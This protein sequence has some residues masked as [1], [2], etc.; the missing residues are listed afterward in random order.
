MD[1]AKSHKSYRPLTV[2][3]FRLNHVFH[4]MD[5]VAFHATN[6]GIHALVCALF[7]AACRTLFGQQSRSAL[8]AA[9]LFTVHTVH[10]EAVR[11]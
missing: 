7:L 1:S 8:I 10:T 4:G 6:V 2:A 3:T 9:L 11:L 5:P